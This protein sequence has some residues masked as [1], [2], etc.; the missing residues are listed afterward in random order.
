MTVGQQVTVNGKTYTFLGWS[1]RKGDLDALYTT[2][3]PACTNTSSTGDR[4][5]YYG[6]YRQ[7][8]QTVSV[9][10]HDGSDVYATA[11]SR[12]GSDTVSEAF[13][14]TGKSVPATK[15]GK[16]FLGWATSADATSADAAAS[17]A[18][19]SF[20]VSS[21]GMLDL[22]AVYGDAF[23]PTLTFVSEEGSVL[24]TVAVDAGASLLSNKEIPTAPAKEGYFFKGWARPDG[25][26]LD[27]A[28]GATNTLRLT[29]SY[30]V[31]KTNAVEGDDE[32][33]VTG[34]VDVSRASLVS[35]DAMGAN[36]VVFSLNNVTSVDSNLTAQAKVN[37]DKIIS[38]AVYYGA[39]L[40]DGT[41]LTVAPSVGKVVLKLGVGAVGANSRVRV[42]WLDGDG[43]VKYSSAY[44]SADGMVS[45]VLSG[46]TA[47][48]TA[49]NIAVAEVGADTG[50]LSGA[51]GG[52][53]GKTSNASLQNANTSG[54]TLSKSASGTS[55][56][57]AASGT[58][59]ASTLANADATPDA[60]ADAGARDGID[61]LKDD[62]D[63]SIAISDIAGN[64]V[65]WAVALLMMG[66]AGSVAWYALI[67]R[68]RKAAQGEAEVDDDAAGWS[69]DAEASAESGA[70]SAAAGSASNASANSTGGIKF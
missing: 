28:Q 10:F 17:S 54:G 31:I 51:T 18:L 63:T 43:S 27:F 19:S 13:S 35:S 20:N 33:G 49:G 6:I 29:A 1:T 42:Y 39:Y 36:Q 53:L 48:S 30:E 60:A 45:V 3:L 32:S 4:L 21:D 50:S 5:V 70:R 66:A 47:L 34:S 44:D 8:A 57:N 25:T 58:S 38:D 56:A 46:Y 12:A 14:S 7:E 37:G 41:K 65:A 16:S 67:G 26:L 9:V 55:L 59:D 22:Y 52:T 23:R 68:R 61:L 64:P 15:D 40:V 62:V 11:S 2:S 69:D 24:G